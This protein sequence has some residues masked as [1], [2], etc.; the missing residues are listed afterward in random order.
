MNK[1]VIIVCFF[2]ISFSNFATI[3]TIPTACF[4]YNDYCSKSRIKRMY[5]E[6]KLESVIRINIFGIIN[7]DEIEGIDYLVSKFHNFDSWKGTGNV[8]ISKSVKIGEFI[9]DDRKVHRQYIHYY[10]KGPA[11]KFI[12][13]RAVGDYW[14][15]T[16]EGDALYSGK[17]VHHNKGVFRIQGEDDLHGSE[18]YRYNSGEYHLRQED[19]NIYLYLSAD[20]IPKL[21]ILPLTAQFIEAGYLSIFRGI[22]FSD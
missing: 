11:R 5:I 20:V 19:N 16:L 1:L 18:G 13:A 6:G 17:F 4:E 7:V 21:P 8:K 12:K 9:L 2:V 3:P 10:I 15:T 22:Y 14:P